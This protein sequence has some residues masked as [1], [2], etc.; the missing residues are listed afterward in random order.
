[1]LSIENHRSRKHHRFP[2]F[3]FLHSTR[4]PLTSLFARPRVCKEEERSRVNQR[5]TTRI[6]ERCSFNLAC[7]EKGIRF[8]FLPFRS[9]A[10]KTLPF[11]LRSP[12]FSLPSLIFSA[13]EEHRESVNS[14]FF[15]FSNFRPSLSS[16]SVLCSLA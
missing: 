3:F 10:I 13:Q 14:S 9:S 8:F 12:L 4:Q 7:A 2:F 11:F 16:P 15:Y 5:L 6:G 1:M